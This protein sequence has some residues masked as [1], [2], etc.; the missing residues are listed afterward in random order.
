MQKALSAR[1]S[2]EPTHEQMRH[3]SI[4]QILKFRDSFDDGT[5]DTFDTSSTDFEF[6]SEDDFVPNTHT[7]GFNPNPFQPHVNTPNPG[8]NDSDDDTPQNPFQP[9]VDA[10]TPP[11][12][13]YQGLSPGGVPTDDEATE[14]P[15]TFDE[16]F[17]TRYQGLSPDGFPTDDEATETPNP[18]TTDTNDFD[19][20]DDSDDDTPENP[21]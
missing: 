5:L 15:D 8:T 6:E 19:D 2:S 14:T 3:K 4:P 16:N 18:S 17:G 13:R 21:F 10:N 20:S 11:E 7:T 9:Y 12:T 1:S